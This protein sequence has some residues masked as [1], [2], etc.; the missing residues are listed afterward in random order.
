MSFFHLW[1]LLQIATEFSDVRMV[2]SEN[3]LYVK[4]DLI[5]PHVSEVLI[6]SIWSMY[7][8]ILPIYISLRLAK[9]YFTAYKI[10]SA[11]CREIWNCEVSIFL[12][13]SHLHTF[14]SMILSQHF[15]FYDLIVTKARGKS[16][17]L[18]HFDV[19]DDIRYYFIM[20]VT[21]LR[22]YTNFFIVS[23]RFS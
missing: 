3:F 19:H 1:L 18:F 6:S 2:S 9:S 22:H 16:G 15:T 14:I 4:E 23:L 10:I 20:S 13:T 12:T 7:R 17:P 8:I 5:I 21:V 11:S